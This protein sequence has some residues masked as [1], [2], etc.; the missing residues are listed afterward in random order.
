MG[1]GLHTL[2]T[3][4]SSLRRPSLQ[5]R[6]QL[7]LPFSPRLTQTSVS[8]VC[9]GTAARDQLQL[10]SAHVIRLQLWCGQALRLQR[11]NREHFDPT[12]LESTE[13]SAVP[14]E[15]FDA[16]TSVQFSY[17]LLR[18][19]CPLPAVNCL[20]PVRKSIIRFLLV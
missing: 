10:E 6:K 1:Q 18:L 12:V 16:K 7:R 3:L 13:V 9:L 4:V 19:W 11:S 17:V 14:A 8:S 2:V 20:R 5:M 15:V